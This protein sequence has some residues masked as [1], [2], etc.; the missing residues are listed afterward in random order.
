MTTRLADALR[1]RIATTGPVT[2]AAFMAEALAH[3]T[4]GYYRRA[5]A[6]GADG[7]FTTAP[8][9][10]QMFGELV[11]AWLAERWIAMDR[12]APVRLVELGPGRG[13]L[14]ADALRA[15]RGVAGFHDAVSL[16]F[17]EIDATLRESQRAA[18]ERHRPVWHERFD[19]APDDAPLLLVAN[20]FLDALPTRQLVR[21][22]FGW[23]ERMVGLASDGRFVFALAPGP[24]PRAP[25]V[26]ADIAADARPGSVV[27]ISTAARA[28]AAAVAGRVARRRGAARIVDYGYDCGTHGDTLQALRRHA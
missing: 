4:L 19:D 28:L 8:E 1:R 6:V 3:P 18:L 25:L 27:E 13:T 14:M 23:A 20:E 22:P 24:S 21:A 15:T 9:I 2:V 26:P 16:H 10:S 17:V 5:R 7:D 11:G 12:P